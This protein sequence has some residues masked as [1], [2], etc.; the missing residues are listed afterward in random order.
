[1]LA[2]G[3]FRVGKK[4]V[5]R[6]NTRVR[7]QAR[8]PSR[9]S[10]RPKSIAEK[11]SPDLR[12][13]GTGSPGSQGP[14]AGRSSSSGSSSRALKGRIEELVS[15]E[16]RGT[17][18]LPPGE[19]GSEFEEA[20]IETRT[21]DSGSRALVEKFLTVRA[22]GAHFP[23]ALIESLR[24]PKPDVVWAS[25]QGRCVGFACLWL[26]NLGPKGTARV[27]FWVTEP[28]DVAWQKWIDV[29]LGEALV[30]LAS[31]RGCERL[32]VR[33]DPADEGRRTALAI[34]DYHPTDEVVTMFRRLTRSPM[35]Q[36]PADFSNVRLPDI[37]KLHNLA[38]QDDD[39][40]VRLTPDRAKAL[41]TSA[42]EIWVLHVDNKA[43]GFIEF[44]LVAEGGQLGSKV[45]KIESIAVVP[46]FRE[47]GLG[48]KLLD[49]ALKRLGSLGAR[50]VS[51]AVKHSNQTALRLY[52]G[53]DFKPAYTVTVWEKILSAKDAEAAAKL[54]RKI[55]ASA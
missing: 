25:Y 53:L 45:G 48:A 5:S 16:E 55:A 1:M 35:S 27:S 29:N 52:R 18:N 20:V 46:E 23:A 31:D 19:S 17:T 39:E 2:A 28:R 24:A 3:A 50:G 49:F 36:L 44:S 4:G 12:Q 11:R 43:A 30:K 33:V 6:G 32:R 51:L 9:A 40:V 10:A 47:R 38:Y 54:R 34:C 13:E 21:L 37:V 7:S 14:Q 15:Q 8:S 41:A 42:G 22:K 26:D